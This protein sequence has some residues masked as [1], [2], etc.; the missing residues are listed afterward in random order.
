MKFFTIKDGWSWH[1]VHIEALDVQ[2]GLLA[3]YTWI[4]ISRMISNEVEDSNIDNVVD[5]EY[6][7]PDSNE[8]TI[9]ENSSK[10][11]TQIQQQVEDWT[12]MVV[13]VKAS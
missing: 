1:R 13:L 8:V 3:N 6:E 5:G 9:L 12:S 7:T 2:L 4:F 11:F 10:F